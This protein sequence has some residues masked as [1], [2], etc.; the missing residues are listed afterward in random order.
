MCFIKESEL[1]I[2]GTVNNDKEICDSL[3]NPT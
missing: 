2:N 1:K 3:N